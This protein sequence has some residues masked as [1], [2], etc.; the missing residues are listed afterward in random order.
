MS[1]LPP[2]VTA[3]LTVDLLTIG[4]TPTS[5]ASGTYNYSITI[6][7]SVRPT[8]TVAYAP[9]TVSTTITGIINVNIPDATPPVISL[10]GTSS[11]T[12]TVGD[13]YTEQGA[14]ANDNVD[15]NISNNI[16]TTGTVNTSNQRTYTV[17]YT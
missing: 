13:T 15:G 6:D 16:V 7:D 5:Q 9:P 14:T 12:L 1:G 10:N 11:I 4:G 8:D 3:Y 2:G 17:T